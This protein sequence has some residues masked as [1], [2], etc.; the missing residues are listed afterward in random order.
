MVRRRHRVSH[1]ALRE[2]LPTRRASGLPSLLD[3]SRGD[4]SGGF[5][6]RHRVLCRILFSVGHSVTRVGGVIRSLVS[7]R[8]TIPG[9][10]VRGRDTSARSRFG[11][12]TGGHCSF[13]ASSFGVVDTPSAPHAMRGSVHGVR[14]A[15]R[16]IR[17]ALSL[18]STRHRVVRHTL[19]GRGN[20]QHGTTRRL[21]VSRHAL[22]HHVERCKLRW[23]FVFL[24]QRRSRARGA[25][26][27]I[28]P[29]QHG[30][31]G[32]RTNGALVIGCWLLV[33][34]DWNCGVVACYN[35]SYLIVRRL[36]RIR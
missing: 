11:R 1:R 15:R 4:G 30:G 24:C 23:F 25:L 9:G 7:N 8:R 27:H 3:T 32:S 21:G 33:G 6:S 35:H 26:H 16:C 13:R 5:A 12:V 28:S 29:V 14:S 31:H 36:L 34:R 19:R 20:G 10:G 17:R 18:A 22:C 2:C